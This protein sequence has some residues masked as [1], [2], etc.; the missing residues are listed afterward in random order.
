MHEDHSIMCLLCLVNWLEFATR[1][2]I[3][4]QLKLVTNLSHIQSAS[5][6]VEFK[7]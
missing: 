4:P 2:K 3:V 1:T 5:K 6:N 7:S